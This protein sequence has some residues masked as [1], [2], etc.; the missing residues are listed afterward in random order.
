MKKGVP[1]AAG[2]MCHTHACCSWRCVSVWWDAYTTVPGPAPHLSSEPPLFWLPILEPC[3]CVRAPSPLT[4]ILLH[5]MVCET[6][7]QPISL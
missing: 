6:A 3:E 2:Q 4:L 7:R 5:V 1:I